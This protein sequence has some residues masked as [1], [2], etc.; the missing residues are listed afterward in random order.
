MFYINIV[1]KLNN[2]AKK[3]V[4]WYEVRYFDNG[5]WHQEMSTGRRE[6]RELRK[7]YPGSFFRE[8]YL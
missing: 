4:K 3:K 5:V 6:M 8:F 1:I 7:R 2:M